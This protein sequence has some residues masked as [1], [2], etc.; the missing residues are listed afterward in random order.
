[1]ICFCTR[2]E[3]DDVKWDAAI[4]TSWH[5]TPYGYCW[6]LDLLAPDWVALIKDDYEMVMPLFARRKFGINYLYEPVLVQYTTL[7]GMQPQQSDVQNF[8]NAIPQKF[9]LWEFNIFLPFEPVSQCCSFSK[10]PN[11]VLKLDTSYSHLSENYNSNTKRNLKKGEKQ[12]IVGNN[13]LPEPLAETILKMNVPWMTR[14]DKAAKNRIIRFIQSVQHKNRGELKCV[15]SSEGKLLSMLFWCYSRTRHLYIFAV[16]DD[17][18]KSNGAMFSLVD[19][20]IRANAQSGI[21]IDFEGSALDGVARFY[22]G[23]GASLETYYNV[24]KNSLPKLLRLF[25]RS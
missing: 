24:R 21:V 16:S 4:A 7:Y 12:R 10:A 22:K 9:R 20:H 5:E 11:Y 6:Y 15:L 23:F 3:I 8:L 14:L 2:K 1:M 17:E 18:A 25:K 19:E 13:E